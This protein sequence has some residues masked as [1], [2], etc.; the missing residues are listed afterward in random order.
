LRA[1]K[2]LVRWFD[3]PEVKNYLRITIG[4]QVEANQLVKVARKILS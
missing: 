4:T 3:Y 1:E 2:V